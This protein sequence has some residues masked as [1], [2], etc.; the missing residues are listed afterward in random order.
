MQL[1]TVTPRPQPVLSPTYKFEIDIT[2]P[3]IIPVMIER[4]ESCRTVSPW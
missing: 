3:M 2:A 1:V 4:G